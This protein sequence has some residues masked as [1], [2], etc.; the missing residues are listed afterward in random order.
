MRHTLAIAKRELISCFL[1]PVG[2]IVGFIFVFFYMLLF[3]AVF[4]RNT[5]AN[6]VLEWSIL[7]VGILAALITAFVTMGLLA[8][9][10]KSGTIEMLMTAPVAD[11]HVVLG[12]YIAGVV[13]VLA[14]ALPS[15]LQV[16]AVY[17]CG[18]FDWGLVF[19]RYMGVLCLVFFFVSLGLFFSSIS[20][21]PLVAAVLSFISIFI[22]LVLAV[23]VDMTTPPVEVGNVLANVLYYLHAALAYMSL[24][25][26]YTGFF[27]GVVDSR[28]VVYFLSGTVFFL[29]L[30]TLAVE[31]RKWK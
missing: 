21:I 6:M 30:A 14:L 31:S 10:K 4:G 25:Q 13:F 7:W 11:W 2:Y 17:R 12:K 23:I 15:L 5:D 8:D 20:K 26:H 27:Y 24:W 28:D 3:W 29:F 16:Y 1:S 22:F 18:R 19:T 9:E